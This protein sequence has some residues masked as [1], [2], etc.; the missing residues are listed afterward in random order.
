MSKDYYEILGVERSATEEEIKKNYRKL[1]I[2]WHPDKNPNNKEEAE[3]KFKEISEA[4]NILCDPEKREIYNKYGEKGIQQHESG[5]GNSHSPEDIFSMFFGTRSP[6]GDTEEMYQEENKKT[7][8]KIVEIPINLKELYS[9]SKKKITLKL[10]KLCNECNGIGGKNVKNCDECHG[11][12]IIII[13]RM[14]GPGMI[15][16]MQ[17][18]C[19]KCNGSKKIAETKCNI[20]NGNKIIAY[21]QPFIL[22]IEPGMYNGEQKIFK[23]MGDQLPN[24]T[25][26]DVIFIIKET[27]NTLFKRIGDNLI[28]NYTIKLCDSII[29]TYVDIN[30]ING[31][32]IIYKEENMIKEN[33]YTIIKNK[34]MPIPN[35]NEIY[36]NLYI[37]YSIEYP[38]KKLNNSEKELFK[39]ILPSCN[40]KIDNIENE[41]DNKLYDNFNIDNL[42]QQQQQQQQQNHN[43]RKEFRGMHPNMM[44]GAQG[45]PPHMHNIFSQFF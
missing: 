2:K 29:G 31:N 26:G 37:V 7:E 42:K 8:P 39:K 9:G 5:N 27:N 1:A 35:K 3:T 36:G 45:I 41:L 4:Y 20:C 44:G 18:L 23:D 32:K 40:V 25:K 30:H 28:Y 43:T 6:F 15:Q 34:G 33:S 24:Q 14:I 19:N 12:G 13:N 11:K 16:R 21:D 10:K 17:S 22:E 38:D